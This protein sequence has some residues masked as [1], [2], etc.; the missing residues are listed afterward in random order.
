[1]AQS[2]DDGQDLSTM[3]ETGEKL[4]KNYAIGGGPAAAHNYSTG[5]M[6]A[7]WLTGSER[8]R[9]AAISAA[10]YVMRIDDGNQTPF[11]WLSRADTG[12]STCSSAGYY[13]PGR[14]AANSTHALLTGHELTGD[15]KYLQRAATVDAAY[16][17]SGS[18]HLEELDLLNAELRWFYTMY[19]QALGRYVDY[20]DSC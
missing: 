1:M 15:N 9:T 20:K 14:A 6:V 3:G 18:Q 7:Y 4:A 19:L 2:F 16:G 13:G 5:W 17:P 8:F 11:K 12:Y 10:D